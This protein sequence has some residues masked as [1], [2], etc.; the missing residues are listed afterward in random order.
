METDEDPN[1]TKEE[2]PR[3]DGSAD[4]SRLIEK[5]RTSLG[6][7]C[8]AESWKKRLPVLAWASTYKPEYLFYDVFASLVISL[9]EI[10][11]ALAYAA[12]VG[13]PFEVCITLG[14]IA[15]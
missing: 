2:E 7:Y 14:Y 13:L 12:I 15:F 5:G 3:E 6:N 8:S 1:D 11:Q 9:T 4:T 10:P